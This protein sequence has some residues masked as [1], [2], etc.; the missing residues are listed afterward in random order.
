MTPKDGNFPTTIPL[1]AAV[2]F[3]IIVDKFRCISEPLLVFNQL[4]MIFIV[5][6]II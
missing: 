1:R 3:D 6:K 2:Q 5:D 4:K